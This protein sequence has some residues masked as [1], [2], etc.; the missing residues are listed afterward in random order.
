MKK[1]LITLKSYLYMIVGTLIAA[2]GINFMA[3]HNLAFGGVSGLGIVIEFLTRIPLSIL[4]LVINVPLFLLGVRYIGKEFFIRSIFS[5]IMLSVFLNITSAVRLL[6]ID[7][8]MSATFGGILLG[9]G[10]GIVAKSGGSTGGTD[11]LA[12][13]LHKHTKYAL[14]TYIFCIDGSIIL[15]GAAIFGFNKALY[16]ILVVFFI[17]RSVNETMNR[18][19]D[20]E[21]KLLIPTYLMIAR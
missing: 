1:E 21:Q 15:L 17:S 5:T 9:I 7:L 6:Q 13:V 8:I 18:F 12:L 2:I 14:G 19:D 3:H 10:V 20:F 11:M 16:S 4:N